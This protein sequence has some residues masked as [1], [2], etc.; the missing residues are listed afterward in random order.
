LVGR[1]RQQLRDV[2]VVVGLRGP[3]TDLPAAERARVLL[4]VVGV[5]VGIG[6]DLDRNAELA[7][8][9]DRDH[10]LGEARGP[11]VHVLAVGE[12]CPL[13]PAVEVGLRGPAARRPI[14]PARSVARLE[15]DAAVA[16]LAEL[17]GGDQPRDP[18]TEDDDAPTLPAAAQ[19]EVAFRRRMP[20]PAFS[21]PGRRCIRRRGDEA[22][23]VHAVIQR[24]GPTQSAD[25]IREVPPPHGRNNRFSAGHDASF[26]ES[27]PGVGAQDS[28]GDA[29]RMT[30][31]NGQ[32]AGAR[33]WL[34][35][36]CQHS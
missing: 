21:G 36:R 26:G 18:G 25:A 6:E 14:E 3:V 28:P 30:S 33:P 20:R 29:A 5:L 7:A 32:T 34:G 16:R 8:I 27:G 2:A 11:A 22:E 23:R 1:L 31:T 17:E 12:A 24:P 35:Y 10:V 4:I 13:G 15:H 9:V 19:A